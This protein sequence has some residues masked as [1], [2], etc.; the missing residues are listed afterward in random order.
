[1]SISAIGVGLL[2]LV[3]MLGVR[4]WRVVQPAT[5]LARSGRLGFDMPTNMVSAPGGNV[6]E[7]KS[8]DSNVNYS[9][10]QRTTVFSLAP[11]R[12]LE[13]EFEQKAKSWPDGS[14]GSWLAAKLAPKQI[15][16]ELARSW[17]DG[18]ENLEGFIGLLCRAVTDV[19]KL[20]EAPLRVEP[21]TPLLSIQQFRRGSAVLLRRY[22]FD[23]QKGE[24]RVRWV[25]NK[26][27]AALGIAAE[28]VTL[29]PAE[30][31]RRLVTVG[32]HAPLLVAHTPD[33]LARLDRL[34]RFV[35]GIVEK[36]L[37][38]GHLAEIEPELDDILDRFDDIEP[39]LPWVLEN[40]DDLAPYVSILMTHI[41]E[42]LLYADE[43][44][45]WADYFLPYLPFF[46]SRL[47]ALGPHLPLLRPHLK[48]LGPHFRRLVPCVDPILLKSQSYSISANAD[49]LIFWFGWALRIPV[50][51]P[52]VVR[53]PGGARFVGF[54]ARRLP[55]R[56]V[57]GPC[58]DVECL[59][60]EC[61]GSGWN[62]SFT[63]RPV[64]L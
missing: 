4:L 26:A 51:V 13:A 59:V 38:S 5:V 34:E 31:M 47:D 43:E 1:M 49:V 21:G 63:D 42:L 22:K 41:D 25:S 58:S 53:C 39:H 9:T 30:R 28:L 35:P 8:Q 48:V 3:M 24:D 55:R 6:M 15:V 50:V 7:M 45:E 33:I 36:V 61:Y 56:F 23:E 64:S 32:R 44:H 29:P 14:L 18:Y 20:E 52:L 11:H 54:M 27:E 37:E 40:I 62:R 2:S 46:V 12:I 19:G 10:R 17:P 57:R 60:G 16:A